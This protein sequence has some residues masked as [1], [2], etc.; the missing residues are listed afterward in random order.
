MSKKLEKITLDDVEFV[1][2]DSVVVEEVRFTGA[3]SE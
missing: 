3:F 1:R 2:A